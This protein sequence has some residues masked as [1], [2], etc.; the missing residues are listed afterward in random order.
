MF[1]HRMQSILMQDRKLLRRV[2]EEFDTERQGF[3][4]LP[5]LPSLS[6]RTSWR[7]M[8]QAFVY[9]CLD[10]GAVQIMDSPPIRPCCVTTT[11]VIG[12]DCTTLRPHQSKCEGEAHS[13]IPTG[14]LTHSHTDP[15]THLV[16]HG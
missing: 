2:F 5:S 13:H 16:W 14:W 6:F 15:L 11:L 12:L 10:S 1:K 8:I 9:G 7:I 3:F 4:S